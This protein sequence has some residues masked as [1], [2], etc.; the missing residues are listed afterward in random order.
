MR[1]WTRPH[2]NRNMGAPSAIIVHP[3]YYHTLPKPETATSRASWLEGCPT[4]LLHSLASRMESAAELC[5]LELV[6]TRMRCMGRVEAA[7]GGHVLLHVAAAALWVQ[8]RRAACMG[9]A[10]Q[11]SSSVQWVVQPK[12]PQ[13]LT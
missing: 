11:R 5:T 1:P 10:M 6:C 4:C 8:W 3:A 12:R 9:A 7:V 2:N 13:Q